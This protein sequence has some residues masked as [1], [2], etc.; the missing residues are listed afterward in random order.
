MGYSSSL[1]KEVMK[2]RDARVKFCNEMLQGM[3]IIKLFAWEPT[4]LGQVSSG[5]RAVNCEQ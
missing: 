1:T 4:L 3:R 2:T 5:R